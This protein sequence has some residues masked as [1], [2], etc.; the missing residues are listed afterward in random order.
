MLSEDLCKGD[1]YIEDGQTLMTALADAEEVQSPFDDGPAIVVRLLVEH[2]DGGRAYRYFDYA[3]ITPWV[4]PGT[5]EHMAVMWA[6]SQ[7]S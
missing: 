6:A 5:P 7:Q 2:R 3:T 4:R 1:E